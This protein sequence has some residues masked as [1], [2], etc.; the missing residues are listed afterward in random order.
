MFENDNTLM[1]KALNDMLE[2]NYDKAEKRFKKLA[3]KN[4][5]QALYWL[6]EIYIS[7]D[8]RYYDV[9]QALLYFEKA[10]DLG[11][12]LA[13]SKAGNLYFNKDYQKA[14]YYYQ[15]GASNNDTYCLNRMGYIVANFNGDSHDY[16]KAIQYFAASLN[17]DSEDNSHIVADSTNVLGQMYWHG[18]GI[19]KNQEKALQ[20]FEKAASLKNSKALFMIG[21]CYHY[22]TF[23]NTDYTKA[24]QLK[25]KQDSPGFNQKR[26]AYYFEYWL[27]I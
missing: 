10:A 16:V 14:L 18:T 15:M 3:R 6:G 25:I 8:Y 17:D 12:V 26:N 9:A 27:R 22:G 19:E 13:M 7:K 11:Y 1:I 4:N 23:K 5:A 2:R 24:I 21:T 20:Y